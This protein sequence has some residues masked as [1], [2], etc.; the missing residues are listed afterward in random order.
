MSKL[1]TRK[2]E[3]VFGAMDDAE[4]VSAYLQLAAADDLAGT[5]AL[6]RSVPQRTYRMAD[7]AFVDALDA[8]QD[9]ARRIVFMLHAA[10]QERQAFAAGGRIASDIH[11]RMCE[12][13]HGTDRMAELRA[14][15][16]AFTAEHGPSAWWEAR[17][18][19]MPHLELVMRYERATLA[20]VTAWQ[21]FERYCAERLRVDARTTVAAYMPGAPIILAALDRAMD[22]YTCASDPAWLDAFQ[23]HEPLWESHPEQA[24]AARE[25]AEAMFGLDDAAA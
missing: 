10:E 20:A 4:R 1:T 22:D 7:A 13:L 14:A 9:A 17:D 12:A 11:D 2:L 21:A 23:R 16:E 15:D 25:N 19:R 24:D 8:A 18:L 3:A 5:D 6:L